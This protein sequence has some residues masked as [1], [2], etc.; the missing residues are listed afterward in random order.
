MNQTA[1]QRLLSLL[2]P[3]AARIPNPPPES[4]AG[5]VKAHSSYIFLHAPSSPQSFPPR[6]TTDV[7]R[8]L[9]MRTRRWGGVVN[10]SWAENQ[11][12]VGSDWDSDSSENWV[13][14]AWSM[15]KG[16]LEVPNVSMDN[17]DII[18][19]ALQQHASADASGSQLK[20]PAHIYV[21]THGQ[22][23]CRCG[24]HGGELAEALRSEVKRRGVENKI[25]VLESGHIGGHE[26]AATVLVFPMGEW[27]VR[28]PTA[29][30]L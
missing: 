29:P 3:G 24:Q 21:C 20:G 26:W 15:T 22:R 8:H 2:K 23:D 6:P 17:L 9:D 5:T 25:R 12:R 28:Q 4:I 7:H 30:V 27:Y 19:Q 10:F 1:M 11:H 16:W 14:T 13:A 18:A